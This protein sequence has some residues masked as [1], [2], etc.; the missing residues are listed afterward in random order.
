MAALSLS[1]KPRDS[2]YYMG[3]ESLFFFRY[4][5][6]R[7]WLNIDLGTISRVK[8]IST[9]GRYDA[10]QWV[11][12]YVVSYS[13]DNIKFYPYKEKR[14]IKV[15][16]IPLLLKKLEPFL[17]LSKGNS[18]VLELTEGVVRGELVIFESASRDTNEQRRFRSTRHNATESGLFTFVGNVVAQ[19]FG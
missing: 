15:R 5:N 8:R 1:C 19:M 16:S 17:F 3:H 9:Q 4:N 7:Q 10:D 14:R 18:S 2:D 11:T 6:A 12:S 13:V